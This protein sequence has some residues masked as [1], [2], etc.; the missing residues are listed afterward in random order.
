MSTSSTYGQ[1]TDVPRRKDGG[2][3]DN[4]STCDEYSDAAELPGASGSISAESRRGAYATPARW[5]TLPT[6]GR[7]KAI[8]YDRITPA[9]KQPQTWMR[10]REDRRPRTLRD[11]EGATEPG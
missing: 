2:S 4:I 8:G 9:S 5:S 7:S 11:G 10:C 3:C 6:W 1:R